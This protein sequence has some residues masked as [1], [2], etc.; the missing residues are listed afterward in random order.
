MALI[1][2]PE[3]QSDVSDQAFSCPKCGHPLKNA[4]LNDPQSNTKPVRRSSAIKW[5]LIGILVIAVLSIFAS[6]QKFNPKSRSYLPSM[7]S[8]SEHTSYIVQGSIIAKALQYRYYQF[9]TRPDSE[10]NRVSGRFQA[11]GGTGNDIKVYLMG[12]NDFT[13]YKNGHPANTCF[14]TG[15]LTVSEINAI[16]LPGMHTYYLVFDNSFS[17]ITDKE[18]NAE[19]KLLSTY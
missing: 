18:V 3:C 2:C 4:S 13:N 11:S 1:K 12:E 19:I 7:Y 16:L 10:R 5:V 14:E 15:Q 6:Y 8:K 17:S 9:T